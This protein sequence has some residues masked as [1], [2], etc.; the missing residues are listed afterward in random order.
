MLFRSPVLA[1][2][3]IYF[4]DRFFAKRELPPPPVPK[5]HVDKSSRALTA[6]SATPA[7]EEAAATMNPGST[8]DATP[9]GGGSALTKESRTMASEVLNDDLKLDDFSFDFDD[10]EIP[11]ER[12]SDEDM[13]RRADEFMARLLD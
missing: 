5:L 8:T 13:K 9:Q 1:H 4:R 2:R 3:V 12:L 7:D 10:V 6:A 11:T